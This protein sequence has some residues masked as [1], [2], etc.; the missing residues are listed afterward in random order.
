MERR[1]RRLRL[2]LVLRAELGEPYGRSTDELIL[3]NE[4]WP[5]FIPKYSA[6]GRFAT[7][8]SSSVR[9]PFQ[10]GST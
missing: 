3:K 4:I 8:D 10:P 5:I 9:L 1:R 2:A 7:F 6:I